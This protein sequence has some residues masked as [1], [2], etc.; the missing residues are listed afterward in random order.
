MDCFL[1]C[2]RWVCECCYLCFGGL[3]ICIL[4]FVFYIFCVVWVLV[5]Y[6]RVVGL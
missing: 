1:L 4:F 6:F 3:V 5:D 2:G